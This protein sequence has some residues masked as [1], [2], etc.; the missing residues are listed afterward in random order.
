[1]KPLFQEL[2]YATRRMIK[3]ENLVLKDFGITYSQWV[4]LVYLHKHADTPLVAV[5]RYYM[6]KKPAITAIKKGFLEKGWIMEKAGQDQ[7]EKLVSLTAEG[8]KYFMKINKKIRSMER[9]F[10]CSLSAT[11]QQQ[12]KEMLHRINQEAPF[13]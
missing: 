2:S 9:D 5:A 11:E 6:I 3:A 1:M 7:R 12:L 8:E 4:F 10:I 13:L